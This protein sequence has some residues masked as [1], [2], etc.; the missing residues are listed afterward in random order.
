M[1]L[2]TVR[3]TSIWFVQ[4]IS[5]PEPLKPASVTLEQK[6][7]NE[8]KLAEY[9]PCLAMA[10]VTGKQQCICFDSTLLHG[11]TDLCVRWHTRPLPQVD[12][13]GRPQ[14]GRRPGDRRDAL[15]VPA[16]DG[17]A[18]ACDE[19]AQPCEPFLAKR[20]QP[21]GPPVPR[22]GHDLLRMGGREWGQAEAMV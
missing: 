16:P 22:A 20:T 12:R 7:I 4:R 6:R 14:A 13:A 19:R 3:L 15:G 5:G 8:R 21:A 11:G 17:D 1:A 2:G 18:S 9:R 10:S